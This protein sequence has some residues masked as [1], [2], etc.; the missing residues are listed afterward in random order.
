[1]FNSRFTKHLLNFIAVVEE[2]S[3]TRAAKR[4][5]MSQPPLTNQI[6]AL[7]VELG[8]PLLVRSR[9][10]VRLTPEALQIYPAIRRFAAEF[11]IFSLALQSN[12]ANA[13]ATVRLGATDGVML[14]ELPEFLATF[15]AAN[16][17]T[18]CIT[19]EI[20]PGD[21]E[22]MLMANEIDVAIGPVE[23]TVHDQI[24]AT[25]LLTDHLMLVVARSHPLASAKQ[26]AL[27]ELRD[28]QFV[29]LSERAIP[30]HYKDMMAELN[31]H[32]LRPN[33]TQH[34]SSIASLLAQ[35]NCSSLVTLLAS[36]RKS[37][38]PPNVKFLPLKEHIPV[39]N[40]AIAWRTDERRPSV[41][42]FI[43][44]AQGHWTKLAP[45]V[46]VPAAE[47]QLNQPLQPG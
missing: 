47:K 30:L 35:V 2:R 28:E 32:G 37:I 4:L 25:S 19:H 27:K 16:P 23:R 8:M 36:R 24:S 46:P 39:V 44:F 38:A 11:E 17:N 33:V 10:G 22:R 42:E 40:L 26:V 29:A 6:H 31:D 13:N 15:R 12:A 3:F 21:A 45:T 34:V 20:L 18:L 5:K 14:S 41:Q 43:S 7:E 9:T 1:M